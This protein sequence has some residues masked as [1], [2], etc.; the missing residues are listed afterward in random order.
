MHWIDILRS[1]RVEDTAV[2]LLYDERDRV[3]DRLYMETMKL[4]LLQHHSRREIGRMV[5]MIMEREREINALKAE[6]A[7]VYSHHTNIYS[8]CSAE[9]RRLRRELQR[10]TPR[11]SLRQRGAAVS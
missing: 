9:I 8:S 11:R 4:A 10:A 2:E 6:M 5:K 3:T 7:G 1:D